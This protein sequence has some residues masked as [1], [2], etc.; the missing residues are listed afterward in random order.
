MSGTLVAQLLRTV[1]CTTPSQ[2][3]DTFVMFHNAAGGQQAGEGKA[4]WLQTALAFYTIWRHLLRKTAFSDPPRRTSWALLRARP[5]VVYNLRPGHDWTHA[6]ASPP[7]Q[8]TPL[9][10]ETRSADGGATAATSARRERRKRRKEKKKKKKNCLCL[11][12]AYWSRHFPNRV[13]TGRP[14][15]PHT[16]ECFIS[17]GS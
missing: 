4:K 7:Q 17:C 14:T 12:E 2:F 10:A 16:I 1:D 8:R 15:P 9:G 13:R 11:P 3:C 6:A 5:P